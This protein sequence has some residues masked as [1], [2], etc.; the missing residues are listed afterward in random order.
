M[1]GAAIIV[2]REVLEA[3][4]IVGIVLAATAGAPRR[5]F[6]VSAGM[7]GGVVGAGIVAL[8]AAEIAAAAAGIGQELLNAVILLL[9]VGM[10][11]WHNIWMSRHGRE[12]AAAAREVGDAVISGARPLYVLAIV[13]GLAVL[14]EGS[15]TVLF[16][17]GIAAGGDLGAGSLIAGGTLGLAGGAAMGAALYFGLLRIPTY[18]LFTVT[19][20]MVLLLAAGMASQAAGYLVQA[21]LLPPLGSAVWDTSAVLTEDSVLGK[22][23]H[24]LIGYVSRPDGIQIVLYIITLGIVWLL[25]RLVGKPVRPR[26]MGALSRGAA[27][28]LL[29]LLLL[30]GLGAGSTAHAQLKV[31]YPIV[32]YREIEIEPF[33]DLTFDKPK[34]GLTNNQRYTIEYGFGPLPNWFVEV[35]HEL[36]A[37][38]GENIT[39]DATE[40]E[41]YLQLTPTGKYFGDLAMFAEYEHPLHRGDPKSFTFGPLAQTEFGEIAGFGALHTLNLLFT[42]TVGNNRTDATEFTP[43]WQSRLLI[44][45]YVQPGFEYY[46]QI[47]Q[48]MNPGKPAQQQHRIGPVLV[49]LSNFAPYG[50]LKYE[51]GYVFG[52]TEATPRGTLRWRLEF[53]VPF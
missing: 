6:W 2:F 1:L 20:W 9:A 32:D 50:N 44:N 48:I 47:D 40:V 25:T 35:G 14:R 49:G 3:A 22:A 16:L 52:L 11:G 5:G 21:D 46:G 41:S 38:N 45:P 19:S 37:P 7:A 28:P 34:S 33:G 43:A 24:T 23:L 12:L 10:L 26:R 30:T 8:F 4:L 36:A 53:E 27:S 17:Y 13:V 31:R 29:V 51:I 18:R 39:Y 15:E 42:R